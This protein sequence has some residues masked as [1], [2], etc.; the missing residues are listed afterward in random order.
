MEDAIQVK[1]NEQAKKSKFSFDA[2]IKR[3]RPYE[4]PENR[5]RR[6]LDFGFLTVPSRKQGAVPSR[7]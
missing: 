7:Q 6:M 1:G 2:F 3:Q 5:L 4:S